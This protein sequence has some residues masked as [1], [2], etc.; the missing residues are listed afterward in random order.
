MSWPPVAV[1]PPRNAIVR[2]TVGMFAPDDPCILTGSQLPVNCSGPGSCHTIE[3]RFSAAGPLD[4][5]CPRC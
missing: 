2:L 1:G 5:L 4:A 3:R